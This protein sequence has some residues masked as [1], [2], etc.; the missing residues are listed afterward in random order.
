MGSSSSTV[1][2]EQINNILNSVVLSSTQDCSTPVSQLMDFQFVTGEGNITIEGNQFLQDAVLDSTCVSNSNAANKMQ[3]Q[4]LQ[5]LKQWATANTGWLATGSTT[6]NTNNQLINNIS[7]QFT[8]DNVQECVNALSQATYVKAETNVGNIYVNDNTFQQSASD[9]ANCMYQNSI[10]NQDANK[11]VSNINQS[12]AAETT[13]PLDAL[14]AWVQSILSFF[15]GLLGLGGIAGAAVSSSLSC[16]CIFCC[17]LI[18]IG[19][20]AFFISSR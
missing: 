16:S 7:N 19:L 2:D 6:S 8:Y 15:Q 14:T 3:N 18:L 10:V 5:E 4:V 13:G 17:C 11:L 1:T 20:I 9:I 12:A